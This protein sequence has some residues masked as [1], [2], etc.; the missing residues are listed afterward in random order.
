MIEFN[1]PTNFPSTKSYVVDVINN[2]NYGDFGK[3]YNLCKEFLLDYTQTK[4]IILTHSATASLEL[5]F[6]LS[7]LKILH[8]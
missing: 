8:R 2:K 7:K 1:V 5:A 6:N 3:Y 4:E